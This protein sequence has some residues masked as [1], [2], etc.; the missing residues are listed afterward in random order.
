MLLTMFCFTLK[1]MMH[2]AQFLNI[3]KRKFDILTVRKDTKYLYLYH[4][5]LIPLINSG[6]RLS[7]ILVDLHVF[8]NTEK[9]GLCCFGRSDLN[10]NYSSS[11]LVKSPIK[12]IFIVKIN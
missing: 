6:A 7:E 8:C 2:D 11:R 4:K 3:V 9:H 10:R 5:R 1:F 12:Y